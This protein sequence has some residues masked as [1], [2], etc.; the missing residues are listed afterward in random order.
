M[1]NINQQSFSDELN[2][3]RRHYCS[4]VEATEDV[5]DD[6]E[7]DYGLVLIVAAAV[8]AANTSTNTMTAATTTTKTSSDATTMLR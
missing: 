4:G 6:R 8:A 3:L 5:G 1:R 7:A 2:S